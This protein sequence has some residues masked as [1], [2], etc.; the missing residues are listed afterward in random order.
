[1]GPIE[2]GC[3][4]DC[5]LCPDHEQHACL[6]IIEVNSAC[7]MDC[8]L[9]F[10]DAAPEFSLT[11]EEV[12]QMLDDYVRT[13]GKPEVVQFSGGEPTIH[14]RIIDFVRAAKAR[15]IR[16]VMLNTNG[17]RIAKDDRFLEQLN[18]VRPA[19]YFQFDGF[20]SETY[21]IICG[22]PDILIEKLRALDRLAD[23]GLGVTLVP[24]VERGVN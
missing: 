5:G 16:F 13:E 11:L 10:A 15:N 6:G 12:E 4:H 20:E 8:P 14:P 7:D 24:A 23:I 18:E 9:C 2:R 22:E 21:R 3:P 1:M 19:F 17:K